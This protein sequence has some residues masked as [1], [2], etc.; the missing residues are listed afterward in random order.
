MKNPAKHVLLTALL[1]L[2]PL[3]TH[4][5]ENGLNILLI[6]ADDLGY[7]KLGAYGGVDTQTP[8]LDR[9]ASEGVLFTRAYASAVC[10]P[11]RMSLYTGSY[12]TRHQYFRVIPVHKG[13][14]DSVNFDQWT[15]LATYFQR[16]GYQTTVTGKWQLAGLEFHPEHPR[17]AGF[18]SWCIW[19]IWREG[20]K[21]TRYW[22]ATYNQDG[23]VLEDIDDDFGSDVLTRYVIDR[24]RTAKAANTPFLIQHNMVLPHVPIVDTPQTKTEGKKASLDSLIAYMDGEVNELVKALEDLDL[25]SSTLVVFVGDNGTQSN[26]PR[27]TDDG[28]VRGGKKDLNDAGT[29][30]PLIFYAPGHLKGGTRLDGLVD[31]TDLYPTL[32]DLA[33]L[34]MEPAPKITVD[35]ISFHDAL[36]GNAPFP[37]QYVTAGF[38]NDFF[39]FDGQWRLHHRKTRLVDCRNL[40]EEKI[41]DPASA[42]PEALAAR[43]RLLP[44]L[45]TLRSQMKSKAPR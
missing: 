6:V 44:W 3:F 12:V 9:M 23:Q 25:L 29:H 39:V 32:L 17:S 37:R 41:V 43:N 30:V 27:R 24:M 5:A 26:T 18:D 1:W 13:R 45:N 28:V 40:P 20:A 31:I 34:E 33:G 22:N 35:G 2:I 16:A 15:S 42:S 19:Q 8:Q 14:D 10:T 4:S 11:S 36:L 7:E 38:A 21:T